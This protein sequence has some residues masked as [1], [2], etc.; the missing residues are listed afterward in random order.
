M[1]KKERVLYPLMSVRLPANTRGEGS[2]QK[3]VKQPADQVILEILYFTVYQ[4]T[5]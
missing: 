1:S 5:C 3:H 2:L 4:L